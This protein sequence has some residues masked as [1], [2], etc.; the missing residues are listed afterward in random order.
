MREQLRRRLGIVRRVRGLV[1]LRSLGFTGLVAGDRHGRGGGHPHAADQRAL[2]EADP[3]DR[4]ATRGRDA[5]AR[6]RRSR[7]RRRDGRHRPPRRAGRGAARRRIGLRRPN[8]LRPPARRGTAPRT[9]C[10]CALDGGAQAPALVTGADH[11]FGRGTFESFVAEWGDAPGAVAARHGEPPPR[12]A[13]RAVLRRSGR[14]DRRPAVGPRRRA[15]AAPRRTCP[16]RRSSSP[17]RSRARRMFAAS[18]SRERAT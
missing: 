16:A 9:P 5:A 3:A 14:S 7:L 8:P 12:C 10:G 1:S 13:R 2:A 6:P 17:T 15:R 4:R 18:S 11:V